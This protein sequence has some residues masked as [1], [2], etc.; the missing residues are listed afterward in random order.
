MPRVKERERCRVV[1]SEF[2]HCKGRV[3]DVGQKFR[4]LVVCRSR[5]GLTMSR[6]CRYEY[7]EQG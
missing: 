5:E 7:A 2:G 3:A 1:G 4:Q 6:R